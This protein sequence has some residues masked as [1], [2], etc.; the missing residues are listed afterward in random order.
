MMGLQRT[1]LTNAERQ[2]AWRHKKAL[3]QLSQ[4]PVVHGE[5]YTLYQGDAVALVPL[6][7]GYAHCITDPP[8][9]AEAHVR[10]RRTRAYLE[11]IRISFFENPPFCSSSQGE[12]MGRGG[13]MRGITGWIWVQGRGTDL[14]SG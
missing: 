7:S 8:Y 9:E 5:G 14:R 6:L 4:I 11:R 10:T 13:Q 3:E 12:T 2:A 1:S